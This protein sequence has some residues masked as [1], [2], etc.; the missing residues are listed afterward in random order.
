MGIL[1]LLVIRFYDEANPETTK[2]FTLLRVQGL[3]QASTPNTFA[4]RSTADSIAI[5]LRPDSAST[6]Y[7]FTLNSA[8]EPGAETGNIDT[9]TFNHTSKQVYISRGCGFV[10]NY[11]NLGAGLTTDTD[12]WIKNIEIAS[13]TVENSNT[14]HVKIFH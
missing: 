11:E 5:P 10:A 6:T 13:P 12:N 8:G 2:D 1:H 4:D 3:G 14:A 7:L 9:L